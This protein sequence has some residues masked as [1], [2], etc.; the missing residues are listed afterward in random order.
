LE[1]VLNE[2]GVFAFNALTELSLNWSEPVK[3][4]QVKFHS[5]VEFTIHFFG[6]FLM[7]SWYGAASC[8]AH[9]YV[10]CS[11]APQPHIGL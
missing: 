4:M 9:S 2:S 10:S 3:Y 11:Y 6:E 7:F 5:G 1:C 8:V